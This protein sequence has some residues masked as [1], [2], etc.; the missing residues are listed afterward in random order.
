MEKYKIIM[1]SCDTY[2]T[3]DIMSEK[4]INNL[5]LKVVLVQPDNYINTNKQSL[6]YELINQNKLN[7]KLHLSRETVCP[8][9]D[10]NC[11]QEKIQHF[12]NMLSNM[13]SYIICS[14]DATKEYLIIMLEKYI[15]KYKMNKFI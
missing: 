7:K 3:I 5:G 1:N 13:E 15:N 8:Y 10:F 12:K 9:M 4:K 6:K 2:N 11:S 14:D